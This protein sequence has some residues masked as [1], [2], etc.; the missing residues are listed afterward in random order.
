MRRGKSQVEEKW[1]AWAGLCPLANELLSPCGVKVGVVGALQ[2]VGHGSEH[3]HD[4]AAVSRVM[5]MGGVMAQHAVK[6]V[7]SVSQ[8]MSGILRS[9]TGQSEFADHAREITGRLQHRAEG[10]IAREGLVEL[11]VA[12]GAIPL[13]LAQQEGGP[14]RGADRGGC[15][16]LAQNHAASR[17]P[18]QFRRGHA[19]LRGRAAVLIQH[20]EVAVAEVI[21]QNEQNIRLLAR[22]AQCRDQTER[23][24]D[25]RDKSKTHFHKRRSIIVPGC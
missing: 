14:G 1:L 6:L 5:I 22:R 19:R 8:R 11:I 7:E 3:V 15:V 18:I 12:N 17:H 24:S 16:M 2:S 4:L 10:V 25:H 9:G 21:R 13:M 20:A 23:E